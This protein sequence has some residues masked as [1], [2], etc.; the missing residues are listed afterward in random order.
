M[1]GPRYSRACHRGLAGCERRERLM[2]GGESLN[3][4]KNIRRRVAAA[5][6][7]E[8]D[9]NHQ[10]IAGGEPRAIRLAAH[11]MP[12]AQFLASALGDPGLHL[13]AL[14]RVGFGQK[15]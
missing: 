6:R 9:M 5:P 13:D 4:C 14:T 8:A 15:A 2:R 3:L 12:A 10:L 7:V 11:L 1:G